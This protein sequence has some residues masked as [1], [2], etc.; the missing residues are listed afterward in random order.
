MGTDCKVLTNLT[1]TLKLPRY[2]ATAMQQRPAGRGASTQ[3][4]GHTPCAVARWNLAQKGREH[5]SGGIEPVPPSMIPLS[6]KPSDMGEICE[7]GPQTK[8]IELRLAVHD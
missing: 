7:G 6:K 8:D 1:Q 5:S 2:S 3:V 4:R